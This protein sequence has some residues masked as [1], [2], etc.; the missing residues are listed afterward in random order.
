ML[1]VDEVRDGIELG[2]AIEEGDEPRAGVDERAECRPVVHAQCSSRRRV[3]HC[4]EPG[5]GEDGV[6]LRG[7]ERVRVHDENGYD[8]H[9]KRS[10]LWQLNYAVMSEIPSLGFAS[11]HVLTLAR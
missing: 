11:I 3:G 2:I 5:G 7:R 10:A 1:T 8:W 4:V 9:D 6:K